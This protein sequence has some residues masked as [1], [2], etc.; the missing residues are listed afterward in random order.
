MGRC[1]DQLPRKAG[2]T[3]DG[4]TFLRRLK[5]LN[6]NS[7]LKLGFILNFALKNTTLTNTLPILCY[8]LS[9]LKTFDVELVYILR[10][11]Y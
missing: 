11:F 3:D 6:K 8:K 7:N 1:D 2:R 9:E 5:I 10:L 4:E